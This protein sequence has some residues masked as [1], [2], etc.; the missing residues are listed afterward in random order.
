M[1]SIISRRL[2]LPASEPAPTNVALGGPE[3]RLQSTELLAISGN[4]RRVTGTTR[5]P[6]EHVF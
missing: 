2:Q 5:E 3:E 1:C 4:G 6:A